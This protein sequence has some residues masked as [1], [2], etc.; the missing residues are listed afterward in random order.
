[1]EDSPGHRP[2]AAFTARMVPWKQMRALAI[3]L[4]AALALAQ[5]PPDPGVMRGILIE[6]DPEAAGEFAVRAADYHVFRYRYDAHTTVNAPPLR[7]GD[8]VE[9]TTD[10]AGDQ[11]LRYA[12]SVVVTAAVPPPPPVK[13]A[14]AHPAPVPVYRSLDDRWR[15]QGDTSLSGVIVRLDGMHLVLRTHTGERTIL[16]RQDT[17]YLDNGEVAAIAA[18][19][20]TM[21][22][23][24]NAG[25]NL[26]GDL[27]GYQVVWGHILEVR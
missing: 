22:V 25:R 2:D 20:P 10:P 8:Q 21:R 19:K 3:P 15:E 26:D 13:R 1:M 6:H 9:V 5:P 4:F 27:E 24:V 18:L 23:F 12:R 17:R 16:L 11:P 7:I 14:A